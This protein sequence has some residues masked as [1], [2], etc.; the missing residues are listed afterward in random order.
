MSLELV[1]I[2]LG[3]DQNMGDIQNAQSNNQLVND[4]DKQ[5]PPLI[6]DDS[7]AENADF[8]KDVS[9]FGWYTP[10]NFHSGQAQQQNSGSAMPGVPYSTNETF[11]VDQRQQKHGST[12]FLRKPSAG[13]V[14]YSADEEILKSCD[15]KFPL[16]INLL[17]LR[18]MT[19]ALI[20]SDAL[21]P[22]KDYEPTLRL[23]N[24]AAP[25]E[26]VNND[27]MNL[28][29]ACQAI[30][31]N[32]QSLKHQKDLTN[33]FGNHGFNKNL[34]QAW[35]NMKFRLYKSKKVF[36]LKPQ[37]IQVQAALYLGCRRV[38]TFSYSKP[39]LYGNEVDFSGEFL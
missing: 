7:K 9:I 34:S 5:F 6:Q 17:A 3:D 21:Q 23:I 2:S 10:P 27:V 26:P 1:L 12:S 37:Y 8:Y 35:K 15:I 33:P 13:L 18:D 4:L 39:T 30:S 32:I 38:S 20:D 22:K 25:F 16:K 31:P 14:P 24:Y 36:T 28:L 19:Q 29:A 11:Q